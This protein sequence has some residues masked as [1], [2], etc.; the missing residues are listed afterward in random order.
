MPRDPNL[1]ARK[2][3]SPFSLQSAKARKSLA[4]G[5]TGGFPVV[6]AMLYMAPY[7]FAG[8]G[9]VCTSAWKCVGDCLWRSGQALMQAQAA[10]NYPVLRDLHA[11]IGN[12]KALLAAGLMDAMKAGVGGRQSSLSRASAE[13]TVARFL[14]RGGGPPQE[15]V[16]NARVEK[17]RRLMRDLRG[18]SEDFLED[19]FAG[20]LS[21]IKALPKWKSSPPSFLKK[22]KY[23]TGTPLTLVVRLNGTSDISW[24]NVHYRG[25]TF[26]EW[27]DGSHGYPRLQF[28][29]YTKIYTRALGYATGR[30]ISRGLGNAD[31]TG[32]PWPSNYHI[33]FSMGGA[34]DDKI[35]ELLQRGVCVTMVFAGKRLPRQIAGDFKVFTPKGPAILR[36]D[37]PVEVIDGDEDD[38]RYLD[39]KGKVVGLVYK[40]TTG[41]SDPSFV[42][43]LKDDTDL[44]LERQVETLAAERENPCRG[45]RGN[46]DEADLLGSGPVGAYVPG[47]VL[48]AAPFPSRA[49]GDNP[50]VY[51]RL[52]C[53]GYG[54]RGYADR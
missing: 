15:T 4:S 35:T 20:I 12:K 8:V 19:I 27:F 3:K 39:P 33:T 14:K 22:A 45:R 6:N 48:P 31:N 16:K 30:V 32:K 11:R 2:H 50:M 10:A 23:V 26:M 7:D 34:S 25:R 40:S 28:Y 37:P 49:T 18:G 51:A 5:R 52:G 53:G 17:T 13:E 1:S 43:Q 54:T 21:L 24:E 29:D 46:P 9:N 44:I 36:F 41:S 47:A 42:L 38:L